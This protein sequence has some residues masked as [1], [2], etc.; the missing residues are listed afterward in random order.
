MIQIGGTLNI[1]LKNNNYKFGKL[2]FTGRAEK[3]VIVALFREIY[4]N[5]ENL[6]IR[7]IIDSKNKDLRDL[8][9]IS[10]VIHNYQYSSKNNSDFVNVFKSLNKENRI[11]VL[12]QLNLR[13]KKRK[14]DLNSY[15]VIDKGH[16]ELVKIGIIQYD[17][18][19]RINDL[20]ELPKESRLHVWISNKP[21]VKKN[22][23]TKKEKKQ[24]RKSIRKERKS[25]KKNSN[26]Q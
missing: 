2:N 3:N 24:L 9:K 23:L 25:K 20:I 21:I 16:E 1:E 5:N 4:G 17:K 11:E 13:N 6:I 8:K 12:R 15:T 19:K 18:I 22:R 14:E 10:Q 7:H 26:N